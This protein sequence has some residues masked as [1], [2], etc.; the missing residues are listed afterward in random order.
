[1]QYIRYNI[2][3]AVDNKYGIGRDNTLPWRIKRD[4]QHFVEKTMGHIVIIGNKTYKSIPDNHKPLRGRFNII[5]TNNSHNIAMDGS[6]NIFLKHKSYLYCRF[7]NLVAIIDKIREYRAEFADKPIF[8]CGGAEIYR[9]FLNITTDDNNLCRLKFNKLYLTYLYNNYNCTVKFPHIPS[10]LNIE[11][12]SDI[13]RDEYSAIDIRFIEYNYNPGANEYKYLDIARHILEHGEERIDRT[14]TGTLSIFDTNT[15]YDLQHSFPLLST[16]F[17]SFKSIIYELLWFITG[18]TDNK[19]LQ[20]RGVNI[21]TGN[22]SREYLDSIGLTHFREGDCGKCYGFQWRHYGGEYIDCDTDYT[23]IGIDQLSIVENMIRT[24]PTS[25]RIILNAWNPMDLRETCLPPCHVMVQFYVSRGTHLSAKMYQRS[26]D[27]FLGMPFNIASYALLTHILAVRCG[28]IA[29]K[30]T[31]TTGDTHLYM[32]HIDQIRAQLSNY[33]LSQPRLIIH[34]EIKNKSWE[35]ID[36]S[37]F[38]IIGYQNHPKIAAK[39]AV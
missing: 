12:Y 10:T 3:A 5:L 6:Q 20:E 21:W 29:D 23:G 16:K 11:Y 32:N 34:D 17:V 26:A 33:Q 9:I 30:L 36:I 24:D 35:E 18:R 37:D 25:R 31:I 38:E 22:S 4:M 19:W 2:I 13:M 8:I 15:V 1:M 27:W 14:G 7:E 28:L 39:M